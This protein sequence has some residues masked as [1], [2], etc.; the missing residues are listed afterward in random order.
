VGQQFNGSAGSITQVKECAIL[1]T[2]LAK[3][4]GVT[5]LAT[6]HVN[7]ANEIAGPKTLTHI[8]DALF[9]IEV[10][11]NELRTIRPTKNRFGDIDTVGIFRMTEQGML[12]VDNPSKIFISSTIGASPGS[13]VTCIRDGNRNLLL[14]LQSLMT[15]SENEYC[16]RVSIGYNANRLKMVGAILRKYA[17]LKFNKDIYVSLVGGVK[18]PD[19]DSSADLALAASLFSSFHDIIIPRDSCFMGELSLSGEIRPVNGGVSRVKEAIKHGFK[20]IYI[21][22]ANYHK[23]MELSGINIIK[24]KTVNE[25]TKI[26]SSWK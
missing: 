16:Q 14:E 10:N 5:V 23:N 21:P 4:A 3:K 2:H 19:T 11:E 6:A 26:L 8:V 12:S 13:A 7:K 24:L 9:H 25:L 20:N 22:N 18:L 1:L 15:E 17:K